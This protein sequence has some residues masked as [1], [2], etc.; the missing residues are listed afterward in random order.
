MKLFTRYTRINILSTIIIFLLGCI[1]FSFLLRYV[2]IRQIDE[3]LKIEKN[4]IASYVTRFDHLPSVVE[5]RG[6]YTTYHLVQNQGEQEPR[7]FTIKFFNKQQHEKENIFLPPR[8]YHLFQ[9]TLALETARI[10]M[11]TDEGPEI[12]TG[13]ACSGGIYTNVP[14]VCC[15]S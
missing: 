13:S 14:N 6:Q 8:F 15:T 2:I 1:A 9:K 7:I 4:E 11:Y 12:L 5:V 10:N 3:D